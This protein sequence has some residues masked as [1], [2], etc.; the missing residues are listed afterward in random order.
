[1]EKGPRIQGCCVRRVASTECP[2]E[3]PEVAADHRFVEPQRPSAVEQRWLGEL[4]PKRVDG[5]TQ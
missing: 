2:L 4:L 3:V 1:M 5:L